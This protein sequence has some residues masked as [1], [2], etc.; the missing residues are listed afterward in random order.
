MSAEAN[1]GTVVESCS[2]KLTLSPSS[3]PFVPHTTEKCK[4]AKLPTIFLVPLTR[5]WWAFAKWG[6]E[7]S[8]RIRN[9]GGT[10]LATAETKKQ[11]IFLKDLLLHDMGRS[12]SD[13]SER[14]SSYSEVFLSGKYTKG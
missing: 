13:L 7:F 4:I 10:I 6:E 11:Q 14:N 8:F 3:F 5:T 9:T 1:F 2:K 12:F